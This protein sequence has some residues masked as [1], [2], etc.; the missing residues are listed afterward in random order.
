MNPE[1]NDNSRGFNNY[2]APGADRLRITTSLIKKDLDDFDDN[3]FVQL[4]TSRKW[5]FKKSNNDN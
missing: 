2:S 3:N 4:A 1:L 5:C